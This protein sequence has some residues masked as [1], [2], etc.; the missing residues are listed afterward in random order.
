MDFIYINYPDA[1]PYEGYSHQLKFTG[2]EVQAMFEN[3]LRVFLAEEITQGKES[4]DIESNT[5]TLL[6]NL[7]K[8]KETAIRRNYGRVL[9]VEKP[10]EEKKAPTAKKRKP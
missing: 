1:P 6:I 7:P 8:E 4:M 5:L 9:F 10:A 3:Q 2:T